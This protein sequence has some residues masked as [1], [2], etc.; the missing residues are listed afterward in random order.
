MRIALLL[1]IIAIVSCAMFVSCN[2]TVKMVTVQNHNYSGY[3]LTDVSVCPGDYWETI[4]KGK[5]VETTG[6]WVNSESFRLDIDFTRNQMMH[7]IGR[8]VHGGDIIILRVFDDKW[9]W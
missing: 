2:H 4:E 3:E 9:E 5:S 8:R 1:R 7:R 6:E